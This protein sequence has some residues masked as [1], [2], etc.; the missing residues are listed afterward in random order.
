MRCDSDAAWVALDVLMALLRPA[1]TSHVPADARN[2]EPLAPE[3]NMGFKAEGKVWLGAL[4][5]S[6]LPWVLGSIIESPSLRVLPRLAA[7]SVL[8]ILLSCGLAYT[9]EIALP[10]IDPQAAGSAWQRVACDA[11]APALLEQLH[12]AASTLP[13]SYDE[14]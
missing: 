7:C 2:P 8:H 10:G 1:G 3:H 13:T 4:A 14:S 9:M 6:P 12:A 5:A 11:R